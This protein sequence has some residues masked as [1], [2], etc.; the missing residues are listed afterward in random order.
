M[1]HPA[2]NWNGVLTMKQI[3]EYLTDLEN[4]LGEIRE[5]NA[6]RIQEAKERLGTKYL[7]HPD[8]HVKRRDKSRQEGER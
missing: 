5:R 7:C 2:H 4:Q 1:I 8:N 6:Q 3:Q